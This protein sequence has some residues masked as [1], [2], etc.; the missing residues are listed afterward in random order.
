MPLQHMQVVKG[1]HKG[2][3]VPGDIVGPTCFGGYK[4][5]GLAF[6]FGER[7]AGNISP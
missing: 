5:G 7:Q 4:Y 1:D 2:Y 3:P 6:R